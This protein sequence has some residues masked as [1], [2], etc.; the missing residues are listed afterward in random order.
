MFKYCLYL[1][2][3]IR[4]AKLGLCVLWIYV[5]IGLTKTGVFYIRGLWFFLVPHLYVQTER[6]LAHCCR[7]YV[8]SF[9]NWWGRRGM[10]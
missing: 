10:G 9:G 6:K 4:A 5:F 2:N 1:K 3:W 7:L 8:P